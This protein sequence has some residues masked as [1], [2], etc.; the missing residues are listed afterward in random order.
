[1]LNYIFDP[2]LV[3]PVSSRVGQQVLGGLT[4]VGK[5][6]SPST[7]YKYDKNN[8]QARA[9]MAYQ[10]NEKT[11]LR[12]GYGKYFLNPTGEG[13]TQG[14][15]L[16]TSV[17]ASNDGGRTPTYVFGN[18]WPNGIQQPPGSSL[19][20]LTFLGRGLT[21]LNPNFVT[22]NVH[23]FSIG[24]QRELPWQVALEATYVGSRS[25]DVQGNWGGLN[26][27]SADF[28]RQC[29]FSLGGNRSICDALLPNPFFGVAGFEG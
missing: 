4:F 13:Q 29:D 14:F 12:A 17:I 27:P 28:Q 8:Y 11:V 23:Q 10:L 2:T 24:I 15:S 18:P 25:R 6:G 7:P 19:G 1:R 16:A 9:G 3:N 5:D 20:A 22:P 21:F 26:E